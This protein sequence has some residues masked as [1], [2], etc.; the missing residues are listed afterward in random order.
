[1]N[2]SAHFTLSELTF[3]DA[4]IR[5]G[6]DQSNPP[7][8]II[9]NLKKLCLALE[10][11]RGITGAPIK[12]T[13]GYRS[14]DVNKKIGGAIHSAHLSGL[15]AD[16]QCPEFGAPLQLCQ[17]IESSDIKYD[18]LIHEY[19]CWCHIAVGGA[20]RHLSLTK[21]YGREYKMGLF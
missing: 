6:I 9:D 3:S 20:E 7:Q 8:F 15:A 4:A 12:I 21:E 1:M 2:L 13:S 5:A 16:I 14:A 18:Q 19:R 10:R 11:V 17:A